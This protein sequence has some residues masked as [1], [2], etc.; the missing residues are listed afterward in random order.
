MAKEYRGAA[1]VFKTV[2]LPHLQPATVPLFPALFLSL[3]RSDGDQECVPFLICFN[4]LP[5]LMLNS[6][7]SHLACIYDLHTTL[8]LQQ[9]VS[10]YNFAKNRNSISV[11]K[12]RSFSKASTFQ[13]LR[14]EKGKISRV[15][16]AKDLHPG[17]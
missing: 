16:Q 14:I 12:G 6:I 5:L 11:F 10:S 8:H 2:S 15:D 17:I 13:P 9:N 1:N 4:H 3:S 7:W